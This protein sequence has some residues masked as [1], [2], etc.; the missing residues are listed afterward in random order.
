MRDVNQPMTRQELI[1]LYNLVV[2]GV[3][4][5]AL[6]NQVDMRH[7]YVLHFPDA[8]RDEVRDRIEDYHHDIGV[9][10]HVLWMVIL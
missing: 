6:V 3:E 8:I 2:Q 4:A 1:D 9:D 5:E 7:D 10:R